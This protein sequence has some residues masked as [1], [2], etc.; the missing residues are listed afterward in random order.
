MA[1][2]ETVILLGTLT[3]MST[4]SSIPPHSPTKKSVHSDSKPSV[5]APV[6][7]TNTITFRGHKISG[8][9]GGLYDETTKR[10]VYVPIVAGSVKPSRI[11]MRSRGGVVAGGRCFWSFGWGDGENM[12]AKGTFT[13]RYEV[14]VSG[15]TLWAVP[16]K[17]SSTER[18]KA[19]FRLVQR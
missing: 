9:A 12:S 2:V 16:L 13:M 19:K 11:F 1:I 3:G 18:P 7:A 14:K 15:S 8:F 4:T 6:L 17:G 5:Q 10:I